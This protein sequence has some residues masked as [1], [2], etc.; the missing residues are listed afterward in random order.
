MSYPVLANTGSN[1]HRHTVRRSTGVVMVQLKARNTKCR[2][3]PA[4]TM[5]NMFS[6][7]CPTCV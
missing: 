3:T 7:V 6:G 1:L 4:T 2:L 5:T